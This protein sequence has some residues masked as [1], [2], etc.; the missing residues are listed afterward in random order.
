MN[1]PPT[2]VQALQ[3]PDEESDDEYQAVPKKIKKNTPSPSIA[4]QTTIAPAILDAG[5]VA[6]QSA[7]TDEPEPSNTADATDDDWLRSRTNR[8]LDLM[9]PADIVPVAVASTPTEFG[10]QATGQ[11]SE[12]PVAEAE[13]ATGVE[14]EAEFEGFD[15]KPDPVLE[16]IRANGRLFV[17]NLPYSATEDDL[18]EHFKPFGSLDEVRFC[19]FIVTLFFS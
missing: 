16:A 14:D 13:A 12:A 15:D 17:R 19:H 9:D 11:D 2:K 18:R 7:Q 1:E 8:L 4:P 5:T 3:L 6:D 10:K